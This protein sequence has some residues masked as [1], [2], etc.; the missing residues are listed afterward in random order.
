MKI[1]TSL[2]GQLHSKSLSGMVLVAMLAWVFSGLLF[3]TKTFASQL[4]QI[5]ATASSSAPG[6][7]TNYIIQFTTTNTIGQTIGASTTRITFDPTGGLF[8]LPSLVAGDITI[9]RAGGGLTQVA[10]AGSCGAPANQIYVSSIVSGTPD[11]I[12]FSTCGTKTIAPGVI[13][14]N[15]ANAH[16]V[17]PSATGS[18]IVR[19]G[20][21]MADAGD[22]RVA[23]TNVVAMTGI[24]DTNLTFTIEGVASSSIVNGDTTSTSTTLSASAIGFG[25]LS[26]GTS[27]IAAQDIAVTTNALNGFSVTVT[28]SQD[29]TSG[30]GATIN[31]FKDGNA[32]VG[33]PTAWTT[34]TGSIG[35]PNTYGH[36]GVTSEDATLSGGDEFGVSLYAGLTS[37]S[38]RT[39]L[40]HTGPADGLTADIG[41][42]RVGYRVQITALQEAATDYSNVLTYVATPSF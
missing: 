11:Y 12:E 16:V 26:V 17:N 41:K 15:I 6:V 33:S 42:T 40:Y 14:V 4:T 30:N 9:S 22:T 21:T 1:N 32:V 27:S 37:T 7:S 38:T 5:S 13:T 23:I 24:I 3:S 19:I 2:I 20:G 28:E 31:A 34:P 25:R 35:S 29:L 8:S 39:V 36:M 10:G 18:Y